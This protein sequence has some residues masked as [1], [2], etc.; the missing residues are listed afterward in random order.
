MINTMN[1][2]LYADFLKENAKADEE[3]KKATLKLAEIEE[4]V[5]N[6]SGTE[7]TDLIDKKKS[8]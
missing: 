8:H 5:K 4:K 3:L 2:L 6:S 7:V 1:H